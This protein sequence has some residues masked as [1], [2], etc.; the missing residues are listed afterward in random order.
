MFGSA[1][2][3][4]WGVGCVLFNC[5]VPVTCTLP[6][7]SLRLVVV[8]SHW[9]RLAGLVESNS[10]THRALLMSLVGFGLDPPYC[11]S[12][13]CFIKT[14][15]GR[16]DT[17]QHGQARTNNKVHMEQQ[18]GWGACVRQ[19]SHCIRGCRHMSDEAG[20]STSQVTPHAV[21][22]HRMSTNLAGFMGVDVHAKVRY[23]PLP[24]IW[25]KSAHLDT[26]RFPA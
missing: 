19:K 21:A 17:P 23:L 12:H 2:G 15:V 18:F 9:R 4:H 26:C 8:C 1:F 6:A 10:K 11:P 3:R 5:L 24:R 7:A 20:C 16:R 22:H 14:W 25:H 13:T